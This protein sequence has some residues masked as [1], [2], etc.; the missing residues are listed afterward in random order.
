MA[1]ETPAKPVAPTT[2]ISELNVVISWSTP[3][4]GGSQIT[5]YVV[6]V[7][8][9]DTVTYAELTCDE[10]TAVVVSST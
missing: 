7:L 1:A 5:S 6:K 4:N 3:D 8:Q 9:Q 2:V 10:T